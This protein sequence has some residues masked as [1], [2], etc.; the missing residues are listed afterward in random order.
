MTRSEIAER[1]TGIETEMGLLAQR[2]QIGNTGRYRNYLKEKFLTLFAEHSAL[3]REA[4]YQMITGPSSEMQRERYYP[5]GRWSDDRQVFL[6]P[7]RTTGEMYRGW[8]GQL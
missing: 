4:L 5:D 7:M 3:W 8:A 1:M 6:H 2:A